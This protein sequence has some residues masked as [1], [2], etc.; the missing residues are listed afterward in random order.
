MK[1]WRVKQSMSSTGMQ[2]N[3]NQS[4][5]GDTGE[6]ML[7]SHQSHYR[8]KTTQ[9]AGFNE[10]M[11]D[12]IGTKN[13]TSEQTPTIAPSRSCGDIF[14]IIPS[15]QNE[16]LTDKRSVSH[17]IEKSAIYKVLFDVPGH[18]IYRTL[19]EELLICQFTRSL[20]LS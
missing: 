20:A 5:S 19:T 2:T 12:I 18:L 10:G 6:R 15:D 16:I 14:S 17:K 4:Y 11:A 9:G 1:G 8:P 3:T 13:I 7:F